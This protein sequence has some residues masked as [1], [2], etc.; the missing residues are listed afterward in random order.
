LLILHTSG[1]VVRRR[2]LEINYDEVIYRDL[3]ISRA[4]I[5]S[6]LLAT[7]DDVQVVWWR[8]DRLFEGDNR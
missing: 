7:R 3:H 1:R 8:T 6:G 5:L 4:G 2:T